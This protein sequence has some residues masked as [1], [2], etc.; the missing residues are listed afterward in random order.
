MSRFG[1]GPC[2]TSLAGSIGLSDFKPVDGEVDLQPLLDAQPALA[3][4]SASVDDSIVRVRA[5]IQ[6]G[7]CSRSSRPAKAAR[8]PARSII[9]PDGAEQ[10]RPV[11]A[12]HAWGRRASAITSCFF[13]TMPSCVDG[14]HSGCDG[15]GATEVAR[16]TGSA[17]IGQQLRRSTRRPSWSCLRTRGRSTAKH[18]AVHA[19]RELHTQFRA[20]GAD[21]P[22]DVEPAIRCAGRRRDLARPRRAVIPA[23]SDRAHV[24]LPTGDQ[25]TSDN[26]VSCCSQDVYARYEIPAEQDAFFAS[27][28]AAVSKNRHGQ[29][30]APGAH[31]CASRSRAKRTEYSSGA[32]TT[33]TR[34]CL[35]TP[36]WRAVCP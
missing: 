14:R 8:Q 17:G 19:R 4:S 34:R 7:R 23:Q 21:R 32:R 36:R 20:L 1:N 22:R 35:P 3:E 25:L 2:L 11:N 5:L 16:V 24:D 28:A 9:G 33:T 29:P 15:A 26:A 6:R 10:G 13:R 30:R 27:A 12:R 18:G 31:L